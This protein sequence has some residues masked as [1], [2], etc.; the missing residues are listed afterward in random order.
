[1]RPSGTSMGTQGGEIWKI[2]NTYRISR[3]ANCAP[4]WPAVLAV[5]FAVSF[6]AKYVTGTGRYG[7]SDAA[8]TSRVV[9]PLSKEGNR[10]RTAAEVNKRKCQSCMGKQSEGFWKGPIR[11]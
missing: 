11:T 4:R 10:R 1:M 3:T 8:R 2:P 9:S 5:S 6:K 7:S